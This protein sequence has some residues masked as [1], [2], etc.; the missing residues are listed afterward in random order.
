MDYLK[1]Y[2]RWLESDKVDTATKEE[3]K[4]L[5]ENIPELESRF[6]SIL[7]FGT[8]G[9]RGVMGAGLA[10]MNVYTVRHATQ[11][12]ANLI[13]AH[14][15]D[16]KKKGV[17]IAYDSR[18]FSHEFALEAARVLAAPALQLMFLMSFVPPQSYLMRC[19]SLLALQV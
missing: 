13:T 12:L 5:S 17:V 9:L 6:G 18:N 19:E 3:L 11:G 7:E 10:R 14:G 2:K 1:E 8:G 16:A 4:A 15:E